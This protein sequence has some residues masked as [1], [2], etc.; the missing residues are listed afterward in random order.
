MRTEPRLDAAA[1]QPRLADRAATALL[2][3]QPG[4]RR[5]R[6]LRRLFAVALLVAAGIMASM[7]PTSAA[8]GTDVLVTARDL[9]A[10][11]SLSENDIGVRTVR[12]PPDGAISIRS[13][14]DLAGALLSSPVRRGEIL[15]D[16][17]IVGDRGPDPGPGR[18]AIPV[19]L[20][21]P[22]LAALL[23]PGMHVVLVRIPDSAGWAETGHAAE[24]S[25]GASTELD[26]MGTKSPTVRVLAPDAVVLSVT[27]P[28]GGGMS[29][30]RSRIIVVSVPGDVADVVTAAAAVGSITIR[31]GP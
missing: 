16:A 25:G 27:E 31:F 19:S 28:A 20:A 14:P 2:R 7:S 6:S 18:S 12:S 24:A 3:F 26:A 10:G 11:T 23:S 30:S 5:V 4:G 15:T 13:R 21:D 8:D 29:G 1:L 22:T 17:R 9:P